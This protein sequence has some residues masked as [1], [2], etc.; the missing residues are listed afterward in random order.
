MTVEIVPDDIRDALAAFVKTL[1]N[2]LGDDLLSVVLYGSA[3]DRTMRASSDVN[4]IVVLSR[5]D[6]ERIDVIREPFRFT[7]AAIRLDAMF[8]LESELADAAVQF[9]QKFAD[10]RRRRVVLFGGDPFATLDIP[11][12]ALVRR[13]RQVLRNL[14]LRL[15]AS[16]VERSLREEQCAATIADAA[17]PLRTAAAAILEL[18]GAGTHAPKEALAMIVATL[19]RDELSELL[20]HISA[21]RERRGLPPGKGAALLFATCELADALAARAACL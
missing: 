6:R 8:I 16:Y 11:R 20:P 18:E 5:F 12:D 17:G 2:A 10:I 7:R 9:A 13:V 21:A 19:G 4:V 15:R 3:A 14:A 1:T